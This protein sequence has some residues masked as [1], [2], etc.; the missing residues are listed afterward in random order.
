MWQVLLCSYHERKK[1]GLKAEDRL[2]NLNYAITI[3][4]AV[5]LT[6]LAKYFSPK[7]VPFKRY[8]KYGVCKPVMKSCIL[9]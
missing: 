6:T 7:I 1:G 8:T 9:G 4:V 3:H 5:T 2:Y